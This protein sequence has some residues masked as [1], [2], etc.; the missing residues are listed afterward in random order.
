MQNKLFKVEK[1]KSDNENKNINTFLK[2]KNSG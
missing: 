2:K 1:T